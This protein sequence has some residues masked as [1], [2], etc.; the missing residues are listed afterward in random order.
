MDGWQRIAML[1]LFLGGGI[2]LIVLGQPALGAS[3]IGAA[4]GASIPQQMGWFGGG[5]K[6]DEG[7][8]PNGYAWIQLL[9]I[10][11]VCAVVGYV[12][13]IAYAAKAQTSVMVPTVQDQD[14][15]VTGGQK[16][17]APVSCTAAAANRWTGWIWVGS[18]AALSFDLDFVDLGGGGSNVASFDWR[19]E[20][21]RVNTTA[22]DAGRDIPVIVATAAT[23]ISSVTAHTWRWVSASGGPPLTS[24]TTS[25][26]TNIPAPWINCLFTCGAGADAGDTIQAFARGVSP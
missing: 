2:A 11:G 14:L 6:P 3:L 22:A 25:T 18:K 21:S 16:F 26:I 10:L 20:T 7:V 12:L 9:P 23:G 13:T 5:K 17:V 1:A 24:Q 8:K 15:L 4:G 19:C